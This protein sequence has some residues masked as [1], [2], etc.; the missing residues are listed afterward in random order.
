[1]RD[2]HLESAADSLPLRDANPSTSYRPFDAN[3]SS[4]ERPS[5]VPDYETP[6]KFTSNGSLPNGGLFEDRTIQSPGLEL[7]VEHPSPRSPLQTKR[8]YAAA[9]SDE[10]TKGVRLEGSS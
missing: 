7:A 8:L 3:V 10:V 6:M 5:F 4:I 2:C 1:M 9:L